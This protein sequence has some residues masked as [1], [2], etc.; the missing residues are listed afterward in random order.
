MNTLKTHINAATLLLLFAG[1]LFS[2][3]KDDPKPGPVKSTPDKGEQVLKPISGDQKDPDL[4]FETVDAKALPILEAYLEAYQYGVTDWELKHGYDLRD[5]I[6][7]F[8]IGDTEKTKA[9]YL[10]LPPEHGYKGNISD[11]VE[12][13]NKPAD[14]AIVVRMHDPE[15]REA[16]TASIGQS[17]YG[18]YDDRYLGYRFSEDFLLQ[19][20]LF[21]NVDLMIHEGF[22]FFP[23]ITSYTDPNP[24]WGQYR[25]RI[26]KDYPHDAES[27]GLMIA[28]HKIA[29]LAIE[30]TDESQL[31]EY[32]KMFHV[33]LQRL[34]ANDTSKDKLIENYYLPFQFVEGFTTYIT[35]HNMKGLSFHEKGTSGRDKPYEN[36]NRAIKRTIDQKR[37]TV[38]ISTPNGDQTFVTYYSDMVD[39]SAYSMGAW[40]YGLLDM[41]GY[42]IIKP[43]KAGVSIDKMYENYLTEN[44]IEVDTT[45]VLESIKTGLPDFDWEAAT[46]MARE[47]AKLWDNLDSATSSYTLYQNP[48]QQHRHGEHAFCQYNRWLDWH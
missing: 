37:T 10:V 32:A 23:Q 28:G 7:M 46:E 18:T 47:Y 2:C 5:F 20:S 8:S 42:D 13:K 22:H 30:T 44:N 21:S 38:T 9:A 24:N 17:I 27:F 14:G 29:E 43:S 19:T 48:R 3:Q 34:K 1:I 11:V 16:I 45:A 41:L 12:T 33:I 15:L 36:F 25:F 26:P 31:R 35:F 40:L 39:G 6:L 4:D